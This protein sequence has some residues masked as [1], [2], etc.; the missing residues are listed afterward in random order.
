MNETESTL[1]IVHHGSA[2]IAYDVLGPPST[3][4][5]TLCL[6]ASTGRGP[7]DFGHLAEHLTK[8]GI[9][10]VLPW[11]RGVGQSEGDLETVDFHDFAG[12][13]A[14]ALAAEAGPGGA[15]VAG[16]AYG[17]WIARTMAADKPDLV[18]GVVLLAAA[19]G[20]WPAE[21]SQAINIAMTPDAP[22]E[23]RIEALQLAFFH[24]EHDARP[25]LNGWYPELARVQRAARTRTDHDSWWHCGTAPI[26]DLVG[27]QDPFRTPQDI[28][29]Y[30]KELGPRVTLHT[31]DGASHALPDERSKEV[32]DIVSQWIKT[33]LTARLSR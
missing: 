6:I 2:S 21:L 8:Q 30:V 29:F 27:L 33:C 1:K 28:N 32:A 18:D 24:E 10:V 19:A 9:R 14:A 25:W 23:D 17:C 22:E 5:P 20:S 3:N 26:L 31:I 12:D 16:H 7:T 13:A 11:P 4:A 15:F